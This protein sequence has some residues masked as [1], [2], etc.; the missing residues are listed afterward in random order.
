VE[1][2]DA[3]SS[4]RVRRRRQGRCTERHSGG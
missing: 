4:R 3:R 2:I 1:I